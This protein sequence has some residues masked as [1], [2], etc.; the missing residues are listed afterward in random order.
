L[1]FSQIEVYLFKHTLTDL[2]LKDG[3][4]EAIHLIIGNAIDDLNTCLTLKSY[5]YGLGFAMSVMPK[6][7]TSK[8]IP[9]LANKVTLPKEFLQCFA[10]WENKDDLI[11][12]TIPLMSYFS[13]GAEIPYG[14]ITDASF[15]ETCKKLEKEYELLA[16]AMIQAVSHDSNTWELYKR[17]C[18]SGGDDPVSADRKYV[19]PMLGGG[20]SY[21]IQGNMP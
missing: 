3:T 6:D 7:V 20:G 1:A 17:I 11:M 4:I 16:L 2:H 18:A 12:I 14:H 8:S 21:A 9:C 5:K 13:K 19:S 10:D 15:V